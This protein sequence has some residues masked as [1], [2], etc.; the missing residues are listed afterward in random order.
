MAQWSGDQCITIYLLWTAGGHRLPPD[1]YVNFEPSVQ[2]A[3][4]QMCVIHF[5]GT[6]RF[7]GRVYPRLA[8]AVARLA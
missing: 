2:A 7:R 8:D 6:H 4:H 3:A 1:R 5:Y